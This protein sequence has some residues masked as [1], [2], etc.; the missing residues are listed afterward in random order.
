MVFS[1]LLAFRGD[2]CA[3]SRRTV[4]QGQVYIHAGLAALT[5]L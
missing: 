1:L 2:R 3:A 4:A 5:A